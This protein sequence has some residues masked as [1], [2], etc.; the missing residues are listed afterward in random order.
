MKWK[1]EVRRV[2]VEG[3]MA[4][5]LST[6]HAYTIYIF[7]NAF[8]LQSVAPKNLAYFCLTIGSK[9]VPSTFHCIPVAWC[10]PQAGL[11]KI[12][13]LTW[14]RQQVA[15]R[16]ESI[17]PLNCPRCHRS[18]E[19]TAT[20]FQL[21]SIVPFNPVSS[22]VL[23]QLLNNGALHLCSLCSLHGSSKKK[24]TKQRKSCHFGPYLHCWKTSHTPKHLQTREHSTFGNVGI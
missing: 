5:Q 17:L 2:E 18:V 11:R 24:A 12:R 4:W 22:T 13:F 6:V 9:G 23:D 8:P 21:S 19:A 3:I 1:A 20:R 14:E 7:T 15:T 16:D 10:L